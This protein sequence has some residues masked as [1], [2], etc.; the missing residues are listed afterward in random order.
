MDDK[1]NK[2]TLQQKQQVDGKFIK[3]KYTKKREELYEK[4]GI[5]PPH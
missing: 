4:Y 1:G 3:E 2:M 5:T